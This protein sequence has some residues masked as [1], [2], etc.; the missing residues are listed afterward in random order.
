MLPLMFSISYHGNHT[1]K[2]FFG[3][4]PDCRELADIGKHRINIKSMW[5]YSRAQHG[6]FCLISPFL[7]KKDPFTKGRD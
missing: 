5:F 4:F 1:D 6:L 7:I 2:Y 3:I